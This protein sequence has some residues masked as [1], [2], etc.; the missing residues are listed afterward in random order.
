MSNNVGKEHVKQSRCV[1]LQLHTS[2]GMS[3]S[4]GK[5]RKRSKMSKDNLCEL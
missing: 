3:F 5:K 4:V 1:N 2:L